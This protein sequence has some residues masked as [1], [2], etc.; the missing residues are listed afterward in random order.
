M[1]RTETVF[2]SCHSVTTSCPS[3]LY[4]VEPLV[5]KSFFGFLS[6]VT[7][8]ASTCGVVCSAY[9]N[10]IKKRSRKRA[11]LVKK[12]VTVNRVVVTHDVASQPFHYISSKT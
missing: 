5:P 9:I 4:S 2:V 3:C 7:W 8:I 12:F 11:A 1:E 6:Q 10:I